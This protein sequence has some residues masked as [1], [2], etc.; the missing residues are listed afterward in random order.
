[1]ELTFAAHNTLQWRF[2][3]Y[4]FF[5]VPQPTMPSTSIMDCSGSTVDLVPADLVILRRSSS[6]LQSHAYH[7]D[8]TCL[9][10]LIDA[11]YKGH[12]SITRE[13]LIYFFHR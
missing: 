2:G 4:R 10:R 9:V 8:G 11:C 3:G 12:E 5:T 6:A 7:F 13:D 1:M